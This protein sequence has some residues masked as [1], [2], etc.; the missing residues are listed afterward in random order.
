MASKLEQ[1]LK[2]AMNGY[3]L[4]PLGENSKM[5]EAGYPWKHRSTTD[6]DT[7]K[8]WFVDK[9]MGYEHNPNIGIDCGKSGLYVVDVDVKEGKRGDKTIA[10][11]EKKHG[12]TPTLE[13]VTPTGGRHLLYK[14]TKELC[15]T[16]EKLGAGIDT[17][18][19]GGFIV[20]PGS[21]ID[22]NVY[23]FVNKKKVAELDEWIGEALHEHRFKPNKDK[24]DT[25]TEDDAADIQR[26]ITW[27]QKNAEPAIE[28]EGGD[29]VTYA[30]AAKLRD[31]GCSEDTTLELMLEH[32]NDECDPPWDAD[33]LA[34]KVKNAFR[35]G[36]SATGAS[37]PEADFEDKAIPASMKKQKEARKAAGGALRFLEKFDVN[38]IPRREWVFGFLALARKVTLLV[39]PAGAGKSTLTLSIA[40]S[41]ATGRNI[42]GLEPR[43]RGRVWV[44]NNEDDMEEMQRRIGAI[45]QHYGIP[46]E[47]L[48]DEDVRHDQKCYLA[49]TSGE[50]RPLRI[51]RRGDAGEIKS[52]DT[53]Q[54]IADIKEHDV[55]LLIVDP[56]SET[57]EADEN[58]NKQIQEV[59]KLYRKIAWETGCAVFLVHHTKKLDIASSDGHD[60]NLDTVRGA[61]SL[62][63]VARLVLT[64][65]TMSKVRAKAFGVPES[66]HKKYVG[67]SVAKANMSADSGDT[68]W[69]E[70][71]GE[72]I[73]A[74]EW[75]DDGEEVGVLRPV[76]LSRD[77]T[78]KLKAVNRELLYDIESACDGETILVSA[79]AQD[80]VSHFPMQQ[81]KQAKSLEKAILRM[82]DHGEQSHFAKSH[83]LELVERDS[84]KA[85]G[86]RKVAAIRCVPTQAQNTP[87]EEELM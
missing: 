77:N 2:L 36:Q 3:Y 68:I 31:L 21:E 84:T 86:P 4:F 10:A 45:M 47:E 37:S 11:L 6:P 78:E 64:F 51:A 23:K 44:Y 50:D 26:A 17:R 13:S 39:A 63:G 33:D 62:G 87:A 20:A 55:K 66:E 22:G 58:D 79:L 27:L 83:R 71:L 19:V 40:I 72:K 28:G 30:T 18:G 57:H 75:D 43:G 61:S 54:I 1:A 5:P 76:K 65:F 74:V 32:W 9:F 49:V 24:G 42:L 80:L 67:L 56:F 16:A 35:Y 81:G 8:G 41:K 14:N 52:V 60:G 48:F 12:L 46:M 70:K 59:A 82:F 25:I 7:I 15:N 53:K 73:G 85:R 38:K 69:F 34:Y 29:H